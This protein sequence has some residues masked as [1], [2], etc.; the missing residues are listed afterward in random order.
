MRR[1]CSPLHRRLL[2]ALLLKVHYPCTQ[3]SCSHPTVRPCFVLSCR[4]TGTAVVRILPAVVEFARS[5]RFRI[6]TCRQGSPTVGVWQTRPPTSRRSHSLHT[7]MLQC[8]HRAQSLE[9]CCTRHWLRAP[10]LLYVINMC[11]LHHQLCCALM[12]YRTN[13]SARVC[14]AL[15]RPYLDHMSLFL[16][17]MESHPHA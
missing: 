12:R 3:L 2:S 15:A 6:L 5:L 9:R 16:G 11:P 1:P 13:A 10:S 8:I 17:L 7:R 14:R 4:L